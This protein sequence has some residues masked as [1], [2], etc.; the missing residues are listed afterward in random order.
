MQHE[1]FPFL[2]VSAGEGRSLKAASRRT[3]G[4]AQPRVSASF[5][6]IVNN[7]GGPKPRPPKFALDIHRQAASSNGGKTASPMNPLSHFLELVH[8]K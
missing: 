8:E 5:T 1:S 6:R 3:L 7:Q 4:R 2:T